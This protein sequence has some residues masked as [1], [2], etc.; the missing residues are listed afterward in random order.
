MRKVDDEIYQEILNIRTKGGLGALTTI[1]SSKGSVPRRVSAK[2]LVKGDGSIVGTVGG[3]I[4]ESR[5]ID[6]AIDA[7]KL[8]E[9]RKRTYEFTD[10]ETGICGGTIE[11]FIEPIMP[12]RR[13]VIVGAG[14]I[15]RAL[16]RGGKFAGFRVAVVDDRQE[17]ANQAHFPEAEIVTGKGMTELIQSMN[18]GSTD[19]VVIVTRGYKVDADAL[20][21]CLGSNPA[22]IG[23]MGS[24]KKIVEIK[25][26]VIERGITEE[27]FKKIY[28]PVGLELNAETPEEIAISILAEIINF[29]RTN[30]KISPASI[31]K[32]IKI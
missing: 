12:D 5:V 18:L 9:T 19:Y 4:M 14:Q 3:G 31:S 30:G 15:G 8:G 17:Y 1:V 22:Y 7:M 23:L 20:V 2:M 13:L 27:Q 29:I 26:A 10:E 21:P 6:E 16:V 24:K 11:V 28:A 32:K 25:K